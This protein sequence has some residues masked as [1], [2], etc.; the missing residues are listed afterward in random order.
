MARCTPATDRFSVL[1]PP[2]ACCAVQL[3]LSAIPTFPST[4]LHNNRST[5]RPDP[6]PQILGVQ[7]PA[8]FRRMP[9]AEAM[10]KYGSDKPD[11]RYGLEFNDVS[12]AV[13][14]CGFK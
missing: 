6:V 2:D 14:D 8:P 13:R 4:L 3:Q 1:P 11:L 9:Y 5:P 12:E 7:L 10:A